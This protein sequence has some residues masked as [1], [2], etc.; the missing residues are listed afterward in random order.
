LV[1]PEDLHALSLS[2]RSPP[3]A[4]CGRRPAACAPWRSSARAHPSRL[5]GRTRPRQLCRG[6]KRA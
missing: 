3:A 4:S 6:P 2:R 1:T 5:P